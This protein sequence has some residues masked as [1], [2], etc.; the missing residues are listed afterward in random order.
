MRFLT[1]GMRRAN[2]KLDLF[3][4]L[5]T[6][7]ELVFLLDVADDRLVEF[8][9]ANPDG[10]RNDDSAQ[11]DHGDLGRATADVDDHVSGGFGDR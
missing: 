3:G 10:L 4:G 5:T 7:H 1:K 8:V 2:L 6:D 9:A 11:R